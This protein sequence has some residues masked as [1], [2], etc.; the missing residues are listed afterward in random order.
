[1]INLKK[2]NKSKPL[3]TIE[4]YEKGTLNIIAT[5]HSEIELIEY[6]ETTPTYADNIAVNGQIMYGWDELYYL[7]N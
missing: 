4:V 5:F 3:N 7:L 6:N 1:M 2:S